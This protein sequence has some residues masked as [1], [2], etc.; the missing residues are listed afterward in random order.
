MQP[1]VS[2]IIPTYNRAHLIGETLD[3]VL[4][5]T[6]TNWE[7]IIVDDGSTDNTTGVLISYIE[8]DSRFKFFRRA[9]DRAKGA[10][11]CRNYA[12]SLSKGSYIQF[13]DSDDIMHPNHLFEKIN[14]INDA[15][16][17]ICKQKI[18]YEDFD[19]DLFNFSDASDLKINTNVFDD[20][21]TGQTEI[22]M[23][24]PLW[25]RDYIKQF[26]PINESMHIL[27][28]HE[29]HARAFIV[30]PKLV[31]C[32][33]YLIFYRNNHLALTS[34]FYKDISTG[35]DS[36]LKAKQ[37]VLN[38]KNTDEIKLSIL[39][40][41]LGY[42][43]LGLASRQYSESKKCLNFIDSNDLTINY[44]LKIKL[45]RI[46]ILFQ[47]IKIIKRGDFFLKPLLKV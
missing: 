38:L 16:L 22:M 7:C 5:Q 46:K 39:K 28:D 37:T 29:L 31:I 10:S 4:A 20:F 43:R 41:V 9:D 32:N 45:F 19:E 14:S 42:F 34:T 1:L 2:I 40:Q 3:S 12:F 6:Y 27:E 15:D 47:F 35:L 44:I 8:R 30:N 23:V 21:V 26:L 24:T 36:Y 17:V 11:S 33:K 18:F 13:F 25:K